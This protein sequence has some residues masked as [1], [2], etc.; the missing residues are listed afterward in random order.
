MLRLLY[1]KILITP[2]N[3]PALCHYNSCTAVVVLN[4]QV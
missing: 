1:I 4:L 2:D 3:P